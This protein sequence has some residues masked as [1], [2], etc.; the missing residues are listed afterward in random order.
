MKLNYITYSLL[1][2]GLIFLAGCGRGGK[3][4]RLKSHI[5]PEPNAVAFR[6]DFLNYPNQDYHIPAAFMF[7]ISTFN[8]FFQQMDGIGAIRFYPA[9]NTHGNNEDDSLTLIMVPVNA[10]NQQ[11]NF[12]GYLFE[13]AKSCPTF[14]NCSGSGSY[15]APTEA[16]LNYIIP[17]SWCITKQ[18]IEDVI[19][20]GEQSGTVDGIRFYTEKKSDGT[21]E[22]APIATRFNGTYFEDIG[23]LPLPNATEPC[24][25]GDGCCDPESILYHPTGKG[26]GK[27][28]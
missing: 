22:L 4:A 10:G 12:T 21:M 20:A 3:K 24:I 17:T 2:I 1:I 13:F 15:T 14:C 26:K 25:E 19:A 23:E 5:I 27:D 16:S 18:T 9:I 6:M 8:E 28:K 7:D 11:D